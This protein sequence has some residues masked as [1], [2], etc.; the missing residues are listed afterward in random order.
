MTH[1]PDE[2]AA[3]IERLELFA[4][5]EDGG[6]SCDLQFQ[7]SPSHEAA[8]MLREV[9][10]ERDRLTAMVED[11][12]E[13]AK[14]LEMPAAFCATDSRVQRAKLYLEVSKHDG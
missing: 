7:T 10:A 4:R 11:L 14:M 12:I 6:G 3:M 13:I 5:I 1:T 9:A 2:I 8:A